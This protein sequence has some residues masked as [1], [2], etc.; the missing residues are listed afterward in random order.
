M[1]G[2]AELKTGGKC[3]AQGFCYEGVYYKYMTE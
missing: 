2:L 1:F 3:E